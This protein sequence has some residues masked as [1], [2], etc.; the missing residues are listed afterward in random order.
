MKRRSALSVGTD[1]RYREEDVIPSGAE[2]GVEESVGKMG[3]CAALVSLRLRVCDEGGL[4]G[5]GSICM[6]CGLLALGGWVAVSGSRPGSF[7][8]SMLTQ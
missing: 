3:V 1:G 4:V 6:I 2:G 8:R 7:A 5:S